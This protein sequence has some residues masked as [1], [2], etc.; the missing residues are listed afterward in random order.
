MRRAGPYIFADVHIIVHPEIS[1]SSAHQVQLCRVQHRTVC[2]C[3]SRCVI[4]FAADT[5]QIADNVRARIVDKNHDI[6]EV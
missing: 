4:C 3:I 5:L 1:V 2:L 6:E